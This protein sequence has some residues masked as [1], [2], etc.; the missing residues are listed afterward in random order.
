MYYKSNIKTPPNNILVNPK[1]EASIIPEIY[2][3]CIAVSG[4]KQPLTKLKMDRLTQF[5]QI[6]VD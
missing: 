1:N 3:I 6:H 2:Q 4:M 5:L